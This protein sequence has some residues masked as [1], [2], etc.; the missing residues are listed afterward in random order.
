MNKQNMLLFTLVMSLAFTPQT[1]FAA[2]PPCAPSETVKIHDNGRK[3]EIYQ[4]PVSWTAITI[5]GGLFAALGIG[6]G[7]ALSN[8]QHAPV[9][10]KY[11]IPAFLT[12]VPAGLMMLARHIAKSGP[13]LTLDREKI[14]THSWMGDR[15]MHWGTYSSSTPHDVTIVRE[16]RIEHHEYLKINGK[17]GSQMMVGTGGLGI[18]RDQLMQ[19]INYFVAEYN[20][21]D[22]PVLDE[23]DDDDEV[24][25]P[26]R[27]NKKK[28]AL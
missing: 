10:L 21:K 23:E 7:V 12:I 19:L 22:E 25:M 2:K 1:T 14:H 5:V 16:G 13:A 27:K 9:G 3:V 4:D 8:D 6:L 18:T 17:D 24:V 20:Q 11:G 28:S 26:K 15:H